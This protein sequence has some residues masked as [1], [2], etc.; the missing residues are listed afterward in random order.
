M[1]LELAKDLAHS[2]LH[3]MI[4]KQFSWRPL[5]V[6]SAAL[7]FAALS[8]AAPFRPPAVPLVA[9]DPYFSIWSASDK[10]TDSDTVHW[11]GKEHGLWGKVFIDGRPFGVIGKTSHPA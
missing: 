4:R 5:L 10:L 1:R 8:F 2:R 3:I 9:C 7:C 11:T 6:G